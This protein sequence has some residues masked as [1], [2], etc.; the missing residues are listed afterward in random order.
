MEPEPDGDLHG[1]KSDKRRLDL[2]ARNGV[3]T[4]V[5]DGFRVII[6][7]CARDSNLLTVANG[8]QRA[9]RTKWRSEIGYKPKIVHSNKMADK[10]IGRQLESVSFDSHDA[11]SAATNNIIDRWL[12]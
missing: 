5:T 4:V 10:L 2:V 12:A 6:T 9:K 11:P 8:V 1:D 7:S 3:R